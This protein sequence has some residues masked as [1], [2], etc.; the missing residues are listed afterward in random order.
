VPP[1]DTMDS[2]ATLDLAQAWNDRKLELKMTR[3]QRYADSEARAL[4]ATFTAD[5]A[6]ITR[7]LHECVAQAKHPYELVIPIHTFDYDRTVKLWDDKYSVSFYSLVKSTDLCQQLAV[8]FGVENFWVTWRKHG[9]EQY[10]LLLNYYPGG[11]PEEK[12][13]AL[14]ACAERHAPATPP[15]RLTVV[16]PPLVRRRTTA[17]MSDSPRGPVTVAP[18]PPAYF[19]SSRAYAGSGGFIREYDSVDDAA[20]DLAS[21]LVQ[22]DHRDCATCLEAAGWESE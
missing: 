12:V 14:E 3:L 20:R 18:P 4:V 1:K 7:R 9:R 5:R 21:E 22:D 16:P 19:R 13:L 15:R 6:D 10:Q 11:L 17:D 8:F 2:F